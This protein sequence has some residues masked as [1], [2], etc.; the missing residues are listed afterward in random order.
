MHQ[1][2]QQYIS[3]FIWQPVWQTSPVLKRPFVNQNLLHN[4]LYASGARECLESEKVIFG[5]FD[6]APAGPASH[7]NTKTSLYASLLSIAAEKNVEYHGDPMS[8]VYIPVFS[9]FETSRVP[10]AVLFAI[11]NWASY[12][13]NVLPP[14]VKGMIAVIDNNC[15]PPFTYQIDGEKVQ[16]MGPGDLHEDKFENYERGTDFLAHLNIA[17]GTKVRRTD[18]TRCCFSC[19]PFLLFVLVCLLCALSLAFVVRP[20]PEPR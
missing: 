20:F 10:V 12:F 8:T 17:D 6:T 9:S 18:S 15:D 7:P 3:L 16:K 5:G 11:I 19:L 4:N 13:E 14:N 2:S 1:C